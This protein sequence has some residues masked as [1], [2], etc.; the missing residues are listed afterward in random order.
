M[1]FEFLMIYSLWLVHP[2]IIK[3][4]GFVS[5]LH[6]SPQFYRSVTAFADANSCRRSPCR[7][8]P[9]VTGIMVDFF[10]SLRPPTTHRGVP[11]RFC[12]SVS[13]GFF[14]SFCAACRPLS[15]SSAV[16]RSLCSLINL[17]KKTERH[18]ASKAIKKNH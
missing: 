15:V 14:L 5:A 13:R 7:R 9:Q 6:G 16:S 8:R 1:L 11:P 12:C 2:V 10:F 3:N 18:T 4:K 17:R